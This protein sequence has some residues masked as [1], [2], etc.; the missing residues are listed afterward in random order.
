MSTPSSA[1]GPNEKP[2]SYPLFMDAAP[3]SSFTLKRGLFLLV[4]PL[5]LLAVCLHFQR[6][7]LGLF[8][9]VLGF[10][11]FPFRCR[12]ERDGVRISWLVVHERVAWVDIRAVELGEDSRRG[13]IGRRGTVLTIERVDGSRMVLRGRT[14]VLRSVASEIAKG[15]SLGEGSAFGA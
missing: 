13:V 1:V 5:P 15:A 14:E 11:P 4:V 12:V 9:M 3:W 10:W 6:P 8:L 7:L 2:R